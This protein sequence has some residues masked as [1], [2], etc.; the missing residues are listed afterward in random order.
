MSEMRDSMSTMKQPAGLFPKAVLASIG[1]AA[2]T[3]DWTRTF[4]AR[5]I[6]RGEMVKMEAEEARAYPETVRPAPAASTSQAP[7]PEADRPAISR[8]LP[9][10][11][12]RSDL[13]ELRR[14]LD[15]LDEEVTMLEQQP[16]EAAPGSPS[17]AP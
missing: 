4:I 13:A 15:R 17:E 9:W 6:E 2:A 11:A 7:M 8:R 10:V 14:Q 5:A 3:L 16:T 12:T 1:A